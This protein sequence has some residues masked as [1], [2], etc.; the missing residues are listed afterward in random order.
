MMINENYDRHIEDIQDRLGEIE[1]NVNDVNTGIDAVKEAVNNPCEAI[2]ELCN[3]LR[4]LCTV[5]EQIKDRHN[6]LCGELI[7]RVSAPP[8]SLLNEFFKG[9]GPQPTGKP[10][11][12]SAKPKLNVVPK[13]G[14]VSPPTP[15]PR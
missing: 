5:Y 3:M 2:H 14:N 11:R 13:G 6:K 15:E 4:Q 10:P 7:K 1:G 8:P 9:A 12:K